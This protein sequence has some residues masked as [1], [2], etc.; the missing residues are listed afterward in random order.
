MNNFSEI[1]QTQRHFFE[2]GQTKEVHFRIAALKSLKQ[3]IRQHDEEIMFALK[4]DLNKP[5]FEA[6]ATEIGA[7]LDELNFTLK[8]LRKWSRAKHIPSNMK[9]FPSHC[10]LYPEPY[11][12][13]LIM[14]PWNYP[15]MLTVAPL[16]AAISA[17]NCAIIKPSAYSPATSSLIARMV[18]ELFS[19][20]H[21]TVIEGGRKENKALLD[22]HYDLIFFTGSTAV[23]KTVMQ[24]A[25]K[26]LTPVILELGGKSPCIVDETANLKIA[27]K[28]IV[29]G[30]F[31]N[32]GQTCVAPDY[33]LVH[34]SVKHKL[35]NE[36]KTAI[37]TMYGA[38]P[39][40]NEDYPKIINEKHFHRLLELL[41]GEDIIIGGDSNAATLQIA[42][43]L[44]DNVKWEAPVMSEE[45]F[46]PIMPIL[47]YSKME[48]M[49]EIINK[50]PKPLSAYLFT[51]MKYAEDDFIQKLSFGGGCIND[52]LVHLSVSHLPFGGV[53]AS[54]MGSYHGKAGF[55]AFTHYKSILHKSKNIDLPLRYPPYTDS[56]LKLLKRF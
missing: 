51:T 15:F 12:V 25:A 21:V 17:G 18:D 29:W 26:H 50:R 49:I 5:P 35:I 48:D 9:N 7:A 34:Q 24:A 14:S 3:W 47:T 22:E 37:Q 32:A 43:T 20:G 23:G 56:A 52:T 36:M 33:I 1:L 10:R 46:G 11:G 39:C 41:N 53:G 13:A 55:D 31:V 40:E 19:A 27:A 45:I 54:G 8:H 44:L 16:I 38:N 42:P 28:R 6:F 2:S 30:K 4:T